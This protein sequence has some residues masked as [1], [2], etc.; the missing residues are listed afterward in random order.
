MGACGRHLYMF[1][2]LEKDDFKHDQQGTCGYDYLGTILHGA[3]SR[4]DVCVK[5]LCPAVEHS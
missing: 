4:P 2:L 1:C 3:P 5:S